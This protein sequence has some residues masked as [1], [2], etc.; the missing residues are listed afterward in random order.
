MTDAT[1]KQFKIN[2]SLELY[3]TVFLRV[4]ATVIFAQFT[5]N[6]F[7]SIAWFNAAMGVVI[8]LIQI[9]MFKGEMRCNRYAKQSCCRT[10]TIVKEISLSEERSSSTR[11]S[12]V[13]SHIIS[14][15]STWLPQICH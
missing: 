14:A 7:R 13:V 2:Y 6:Q 8:I 1:Y 3:S 15:I 4:G 11:F 5:I 9:L 10:C 12:L